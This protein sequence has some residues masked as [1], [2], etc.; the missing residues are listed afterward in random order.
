MAS[1]SS[2]PERKLDEI[3][4]PRAAMMTERSRYFNHRLT[5]MDTD[6]LAAKK[7]KTHKVSPSPPT[8]L[9]GRGEVAR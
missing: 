8:E 1:V 7:H 6:S 9:E 2:R 4:T 5:Q 3:V